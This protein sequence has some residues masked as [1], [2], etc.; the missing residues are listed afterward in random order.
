M[1]K[2]VLKNIETKIEK[3]DKKLDAEIN[4]IAKEIKTM[5]DVLDKK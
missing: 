2:K 5:N 3:T 4:K 1:E